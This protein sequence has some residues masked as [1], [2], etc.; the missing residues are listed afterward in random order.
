MPALLGIV[1]LILV[2]AA[3]A[4]KPD[5]RLYQFQK[6]C[7]QIAAQTFSRESRNDEDLDYYRAHYNADLNICFYVEALT[8]FTPKGINR[9]IYLYDLETKRIY[10][11]FHSSTN[12]GLFYCGVGDKECHSEAE[13]YELLKLYMEG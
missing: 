4:A 5:M 1:A 8:S 3:T 6:N 9:W 12:I 2:T 10:G 7:D 11:G 13:W